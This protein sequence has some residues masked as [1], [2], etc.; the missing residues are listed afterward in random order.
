MNKNIYI[1]KVDTEGGDNYVYAFKKE[2]SKTEINNL[3]ITE[4]AE[5]HEEGLAYTKLIRVELR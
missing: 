4:H 3:L 1:L 2:P 5:A